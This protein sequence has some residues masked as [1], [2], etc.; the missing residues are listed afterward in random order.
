MSGG[1][2]CQSVTSGAIAGAMPGARRGAL[3]LCLHRLVQPLLRAAFVVRVSFAVARACL[4]TTRSPNS[5]QSLFVN[6]TDASDYAR[7]SSSIRRFRIWPYHLYR[8]PY[9]AQHGSTCR[10]LALRFWRKSMTKRKPF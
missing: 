5:L 8:K 1:R 6:N 7:L 10:N 3:R 9:Q 4:V 2:N